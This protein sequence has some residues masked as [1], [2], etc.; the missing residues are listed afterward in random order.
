MM[1][2]SI[3]GRYITKYGKGKERENLP[4]IEEISKGKEHANTQKLN[5]NNL[6]VT[7]VFLNQKRVNV[8]EHVMPSLSCVHIHSLS[9]D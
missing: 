6:T 9:S 2:I 1:I 8:C 4:R 7:D 3:F 5:Q